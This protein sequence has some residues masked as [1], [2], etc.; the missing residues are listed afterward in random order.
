MVGEGDSCF[1]GD[2][3]S[4]VTCFLVDNMSVVLS[5]GRARVCAISASLCKCELRRFHAYSLACWIF[6]AVRWIPIGVERLGCDTGEHD[7]SES[8]PLTHLLTA[9]LCPC[10]SNLPPSD[11]PRAMGQ[12]CAGVVAENEPSEPD[13][14][15]AVAHRNTIPYLVH[16]ASE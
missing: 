16:V 11:V 4:V 3:L 12:F 1:L 2:H 6:L 9:P 8:K 14:R 15:P 5:L 13:T 7:R 10:R